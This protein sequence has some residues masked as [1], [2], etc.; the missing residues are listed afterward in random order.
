MD[1]ATCRRLT[2]DLGG[3]SAE[4]AAD[5]REQMLAPGPTQQAARQLHADE[6]VGEDFALW[7]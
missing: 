3:L 4:F 7:S 1:A 2:A 6:K 5:L